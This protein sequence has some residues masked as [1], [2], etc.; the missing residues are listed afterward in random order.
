MDISPAAF[1]LGIKTV[2]NKNRLV[3]KVLDI[4]TLQISTHVCMF[5][6]GKKRAHEMTIQ[7]GAGYGQNNLRIHEK[8]PW[9]LEISPKAD[10]NTWPTWKTHENTWPA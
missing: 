2:P 3:E 1:Q 5:V 10:Q 7:M 8:H 9:A 4:W 6:I